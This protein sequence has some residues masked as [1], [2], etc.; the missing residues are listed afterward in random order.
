[1]EGLIPFD[2]VLSLIRVAGA[3]NGSGALVC[4]AETECD[5][6]SRLLGA[7]FAFVDEQVLDSVGNSPT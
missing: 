4:S 6:S 5:L 3:F 1:M 7:E 2:G